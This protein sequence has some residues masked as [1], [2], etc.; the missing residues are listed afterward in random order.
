MRH[1][2]RV[3]EKCRR[4]RIYLNPKKS[5]FRLEEGKLLGHIISKDRIKID[6]SRIESIQKLE[7][8]RNIKELQS[9]IG[10]INVLQI[11]IPNLAE[12]LR[13][14][15]NMLKTYVRI[16]WDTESRQSFEQVKQALTQAPVLI[17]H[18]FTKDFYLFSFASEYT[19]A[20]VLL[21]KNSEG[22]EQPIAFFSKALRDVALNYKIMEKQAFALVKAIKYFRVYI[23]HSHTIAYVLNVVVKDILT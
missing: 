20:A 14:I 19:I 10:K 6:P 16:K 9:F 23:L 1:L 15:T 5:L 7:H 17:S 12:L 18:D 4:F 2:R 22:Y 21:Q 11:F 8:P 13:I 3:F